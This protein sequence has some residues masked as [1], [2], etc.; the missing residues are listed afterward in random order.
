MYVNLFDKLTLSVTHIGTIKLCDQ[1][2]LLDVLC[3]PQFTY[4]RVSASKLTQHSTT[5]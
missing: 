5:F 4:N 2:V 3:V 1:V